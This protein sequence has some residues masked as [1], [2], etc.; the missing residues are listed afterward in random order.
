MSGCVENRENSDAG[1]RKCY[2]EVLTSLNVRAQCISHHFTWTHVQTQRCAS[3]FFHEENFM[4]SVVY[5]L[6]YA[7]AH[8]CNCSLWTFLT[9]FIKA[10][11]IGVL[12]NVVD[13]HVI[14]S[15]TVR[16]WQLFQDIF[17]N[18]M[19]IFTKIK[20]EAFSKVTL[21]N[22]HIWHH[23]SFIAAPAELFVWQL[24]RLVWRSCYMRRCED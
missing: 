4:Q 3:D 16:V 12:P 10:Y 8:H 17:G 21:S 11:I 14:C 13:H 24:R 20:I 18:V 2:S 9:M 6:L 5:P 23:V 15:V 7:W 22:L 19:K 1:R